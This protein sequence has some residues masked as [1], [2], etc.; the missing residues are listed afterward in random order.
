MLEFLVP[1]KARRRLLQLLFTEHATGSTA[2]LAERAHVGFA[3]AYRELRAMEMHSLVCS[4]RVDGTEVFAAN[5]THP[6]SEPLRTLVSSSA[7]RATDDSDDQTRNALFTLGAPTFGREV[8]VDDVD[9]AVVEGVEL[10]HR[11]GTVAS[12]LPVVLYKQRERLSPDQLV[13]YARDLGEKRAM[14]FFLELTTELSGDSRFATWAE[15][16][17]DRRCSGVRYLFVDD[18]RSKLAREV[19]ERNTP[20]VARRWNL[21]ANT[22]LDAFESM[23][24]KH[25]NA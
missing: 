24:L 5:E 2:E 15:R 3:S 17:R 23:F 19:A 22:G 18:T 8:P 14:G 11:D 25:A 9:L 16:L 12:V 1:S 10:S 21:R 20:D 7:Q 13:R 4:K 6:L